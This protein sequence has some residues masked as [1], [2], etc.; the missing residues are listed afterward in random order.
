MKIHRIVIFAKAPRAGY[1]KTRLIPALGAD[2]AARLARRMLTHMVNQA[3]DA[4]VGPTE[5][6]MTPGR[7]SDLG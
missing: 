3:L 2:G 4:G 7:R 5:L 6:C 1:A